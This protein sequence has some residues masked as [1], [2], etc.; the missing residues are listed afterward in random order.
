MGD[1]T[2]AESVVASE[3]LTVRYNLLSTA[4][5][6]KVLY[7]SIKRTF[8]IAAS[9]L[10]LIIASPVMLLTAVLIKTNDGGPAIYKQKRIGKDG[11]EFTIYK[12]RSMHIDADAR[13]AEM[14]KS[15][16]AVAEEYARNAKLKD[17]PRITKVGKFIRKSSIDE[18]PQLLNILKGEMSIVGPRPLV[19]G[20]LSE[21]GGNGAIYQSVRPGITGWWACNGRSDVEEY[22]DRLKLEYYYV[23]NCGISLDVKCIVKTIAA[24]CGAKGAE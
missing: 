22:E 21:H 1:N 16:P 23:E 8:D 5:L 4:Y 15:D 13:L 9:A 24:V 11:K 7:L 6:K 2:K 17:D 19:N 12:F 3:Q 18:L 14:L 10:G 20:E